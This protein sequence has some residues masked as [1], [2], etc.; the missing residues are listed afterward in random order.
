MTEEKDVQNEITLLDN[1]SIVDI[2]KKTQDVA[3]DILKA[4]YSMELENYKLNKLKQLYLK[5][6]FG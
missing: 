6:F 1:N 4:I 5:K 3:N 2:D